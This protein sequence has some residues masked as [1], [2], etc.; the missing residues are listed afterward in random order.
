MFKVAHS[1]PTGVSRSRGFTRADFTVVLLAF[2]LELA[3][4][5]PA[6]SGSLSGVLAV[7]AFVYMAGGFIPLL[8]RHRAPM[9]VFAGLLLHQAIFVFFVTPNYFDFSAVYLVP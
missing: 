6:T 1:G 5:F 8:W 9:L 4:F 3:S 2:A 7:A